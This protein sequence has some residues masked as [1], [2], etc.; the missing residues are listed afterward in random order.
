MASDLLNAIDAVA[1]VAL[2]LHRKVKRPTMT[3]L[4]DFLFPAPAPRRAGEIYVWWERRRLHYNALVGGM[5]MIS[6]IFNQIVT[7]IPPDPHVGIPN[8]WLAPIVVGIAAN[9]C[10]FLGPMAE[11][12]L[13]RL[14]REKLLPA[15]P[16]FYRMGLTFSMGLVFLPIPITIFDYV[17][18]TLKWLL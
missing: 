4:T 8:P 3:A 14:W 16:M 12:A 10:Y 15:G 11:I 2:T 9:I 18:R 17:I 13:F 7:R 6:L 5:G 1:E